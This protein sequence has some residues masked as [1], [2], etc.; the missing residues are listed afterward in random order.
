MP[1]ND[2][3]TMTIGHIIT[4]ENGDDMDVIITVEY[5]VSGDYWGGDYYN[6]PEYPDYEFNFISAREDSKNPT[7]LT[8][9][10]IAICESYVDSRD[11]YDSLVEK[12]ENDE[13]YVICDERPDDMYDD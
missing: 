5:S 10:Q 3:G 8:E 4:D 7:P 12:Y 2:T 11:G 6:P 9:A 1:R 13:R